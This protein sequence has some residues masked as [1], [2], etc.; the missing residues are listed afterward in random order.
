MGRRVYPPPQVLTALKALFGEGVEHVAVIENSTIARLHGRVTATTRLRRIYLRDSALIF[1]QDSEL[2]LHEYCHVL[3]QWE[4]GKLTILRY[5]IESARHG[6]W[7]NRF[8]VEARR[9][10]CENLQRFLELLKWQ[11]S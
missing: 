7:N 3:L 4:S 8:E 1:F 11:T 9:F 10:A 2:M 6:Y 5:L